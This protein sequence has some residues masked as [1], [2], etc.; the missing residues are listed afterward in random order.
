MRLGKALFVYFLIFI[1]LFLAGVYVFG[2]NYLKRLERKSAQV[3][4]PFP[5]ATPTTRPPPTEISLVVTGDVMLA[6]SVTTKMRALDNFAYPF[7]E[8]AAV[9]KE[10]DLTLINL[11]SPFGS[12]CS[13][14]DTGM[15]FCADQQAIEG[16]IKAGVDLVSLA[17]NHVLDQGEAGLSETIQLIKQNFMT[18]VGLRDP[19]F[20]EVNG[21]KLVFL[22]Y[23]AVNPQS[24][25]VSWADP[26]V[27]E[28][29]IKR[30][31]REA[32]VL[33]VYFHWGQEYA[34]TPRS[35][36]G[37]P[38]DP[39]KL[40]HQAI[41]AGADLVLGSHPHVV[42]DNEWYNGKLI[43]YSLG[44]FVFDQSWSQETQKGTLGKFI[45]DQ[46]GL[47]S[48]DFLPV[49]I[50]NYQPVFTDNSSS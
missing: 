25:L 13:S 30:F 16:L 22:A 29:E 42:W 15:V 10:A 40:A 47:V 27:I 41:D 49:E 20:L 44:N 34:E 46:E 8:T 24:T 19:A 28:S 9:L 48:A 37:S 14:T 36:S 43:V 39:K 45:L 33:V 31:S 12:N 18:P 2:R 5:A 1:C 11:E 32:D 6:R 17:N 50:I 26:A 38:F 21:V 35:G 23:N 3:I 7:T 4:L